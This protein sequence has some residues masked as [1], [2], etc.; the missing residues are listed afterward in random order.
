MIARVIKAHV[1]G[2]EVGFSVLRGKKTGGGLE[3]L[4]E[5]VK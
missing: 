4:S 3:A 1:E 2:A 5:R